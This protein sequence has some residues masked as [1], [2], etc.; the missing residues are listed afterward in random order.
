M[1]RSRTIGWEKL[2]QQKFF[3]LLCDVL[4]ESSDHLNT[5][6]QKIISLRR[7]V[8]HTCHLC[9]RTWDVLHVENEA[10]YKCRRRH[11]KS[12]VLIEFQP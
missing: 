6:K 3:L 2:T 4:N 10:K 8:N 12:V 5:T 1:L 11:N 7:A 9:A